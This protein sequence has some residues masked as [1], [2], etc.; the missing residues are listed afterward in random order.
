MDTLGSGHRV[1]HLACGALAF[2]L[3]TG[4][5]ASTDSQ[6]PAPTLPERH[7]EW[8][9]MVDRLITE[10]EKAYFLSIGEDYR[11]DAF[12]DQVEYQYGS[13][14]NFLETLRADLLRQKL[15]RLLRLRGL[16]PAADARVSS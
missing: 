11:R 7:A 16:G 8:L 6:G 12:I 5:G 2:L 9:D 15:A 10:E 3:A 14:Q 1:Q 4:A 13:Q